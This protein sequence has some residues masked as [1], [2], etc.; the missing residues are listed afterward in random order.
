M[1]FELLLASFGFFLL[2][3]F[4]FGCGTS[5]K[6]S[7]SIWLICSQFVVS[8]SNAIPLSSLKWLYCEWFPYES[9]RRLVVW[10]I[11]KLLRG[12]EKTE[13]DGDGDWKFSEIG[14][15]MKCPWLNGLDGDD[16]G[17]MWKFGSSVENKY[18]NFIRF[19]FF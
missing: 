2:L 4:L 18:K 15:K 10:L 7:S 9:N 1:I 8:C 3:D 6:I 13:V 12:D 19:L 11:L 17:L 5:L 16:G 14:G